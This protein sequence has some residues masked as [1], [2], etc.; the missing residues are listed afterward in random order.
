M[1]PDDKSIFRRERKKSLV[2]QRLEVVVQ[3]RYVT[4]HFTCRLLQQACNK[5][6]AWSISYFCN[7]TRSCSAV[8]FKAEAP[9]SIPHSCTTC[10]LLRLLGHINLAWL[11]SKAEQEKLSRR[12]NE[13][14]GVRQR[15]REHTQRIR[16]MG[17]SLSRNARVLVAM[18]SVQVSVNVK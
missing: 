11:R 14:G 1:S 16:G 15:E 8:N 5:N 9:G 13:P 3:V 18:H 6:P 10:L 12:G 17:Q 7:T 4:W 2:S